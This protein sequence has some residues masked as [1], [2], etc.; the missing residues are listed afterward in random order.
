MNHI[1]IIDM[2]GDAIEAGHLLGKR[3]SMVLLNLSQMTG[4]VDDSVKT[5][6]VKAEQ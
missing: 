1:L 4:I 2:K 6:S 3:D 5:N